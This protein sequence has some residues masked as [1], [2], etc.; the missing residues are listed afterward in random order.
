MMDLGQELTRRTVAHRKAV[1]SV[2]IGW[3]NKYRVTLSDIE[4][5]RQKEVAGLR[6]HLKE[7]GYAG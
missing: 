4:G 3:W 5:Q 7:L 1:E 2:V 6:G